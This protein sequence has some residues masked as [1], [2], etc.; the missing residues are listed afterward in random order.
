MG[1]GVLRLGGSVLRGLG[2]L[3]DQ[4]E[5]ALLR[6]NG[7]LGEVSPVNRLGKLVLQC[8]LLTVCAD[9]GSH[10]GPGGNNVFYF[11]LLLLL[12]FLFSN[13][14]FVLYVMGRGLRILQCVHMV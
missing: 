5:T 13:R 11:L 14:L 1:L 2:V 6:P 9:R 4:L 12:A 7:Y 3:V 8:E 10:F